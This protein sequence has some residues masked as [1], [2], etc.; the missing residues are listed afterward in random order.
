M[1]NKQAILNLLGIARRAGQLVSGEDT[2]LKAIRSHQA[3]FVIIAADAGN[4]TSKKFQDK[5]HFYEV[6]FDMTFE[7]Q[8]LNQ[9]TGQARTVYG[10]TQ[11]GFAHKIEELLRM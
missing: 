11:S 9:A 3:Q 10:I 6:K 4:A 7:K 5:C 2:V 1:T 8:Q